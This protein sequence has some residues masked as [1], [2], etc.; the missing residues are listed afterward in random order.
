MEIFKTTLLPMSIYGLA[1][2]IAGILL[3]TTVGS[4]VDR[5]PRLSAVQRFLFIQKFTTVLG[6][7]GFW[8]LL[9]WFD[10]SSTG[11][12]GSSALSYSQGNSIFAFLVLSS[13]VLKLS[14]LGWSISIE[15]DWIVALCQSN[16]EALTKLNANM[17]RIDLICKLVSPLIFAAVLT[18]VN[19]GYCSLIIA[20][21]CMF[22]FTIELILVR[23]IWNR[24]PILW[25]ARSLHSK[26]SFSYAIIYINMMSV[27]GTMIGFLQWKGLTAGSIALLKGVCTISELI[28]TLVMPIMTRYVGLVRTGAWSIWFEVIALTPVLF[29]IYSDRMP[30]QFLIF[31]GMALSRVGVWSFDLVITQTMQEYIEAGNNNA[32]VLNGW[33]YSMMNVFELA[34]FFL[35]MIWSNPDKY[36]IPCTL[37]FVCIV[38]GALVYSTYVIRMRGHLFHSRRKTSAASPCLTTDNPELEQSGQMEDIQPGPSRSDHPN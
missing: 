11:P 5:T 17:K 18:K 8:V 31:A 29:S 36:F 1:T 37:S 34:Q 33:H 32:G 10:P 22:S 4:I 12:G 15:R 6:A 24:S 2:T 27:S 9:T 3:S 26:A 28:G 14:A 21:W 7:L 20:T 19:A 25:Q 30:I 23:R 35:T 38:F 16:S 13:G